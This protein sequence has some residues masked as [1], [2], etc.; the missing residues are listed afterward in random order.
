MNR[1]TGVNPALCLVMVCL[2]CS[3]PGGSDPGDTDAGSTPSAGTGGSESASGGA[4]LLP[5]AGGSTGG[6]SSIGGSSAG[7]TGGSPSGSSGSGGTAI[8]TAGGGGSGG[9]GGTAES[10]FPE[11]GA[12]LGAFVGTGPAADFEMALGRKLSVRLSYYGWPH[13]FTGGATSEDIAA[14]RIPYITWEPQE[15]TLDAIISG[16]EDALIEQRALGLKAHGVPIMLRWAHEMNGDWYPWGG[17]NNGGEGVGPA[18]YIAAYRHIHDVFAAAGASNVLWVWCPMDAHSPYEPWNHFSNYYPGDEYVD[19]AAVDGYN[20]GSTQP[21]GWNSFESIFD[22]FYAAYAGSGKPIM[23]GETASTEEGG[24]KAA[25]IT[26]MHSVIKASMP[27]LKVLVWFHIDKETDWR[28]NS[29]TAAQ[30]AFQAVAS[31]P[32]FAP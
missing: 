27:A 21:W 22:E 16:S 3:T 30:T 8:S 5:G 15:V 19:V 6:G 32:Y 7:G 13:D 10:L 26:D 23:V 12:L 17:A 9:T 4:S 18:K 20:W 2:A 14:G 11:D 28:V 24:D 1:L 25:W 31:D 29:S